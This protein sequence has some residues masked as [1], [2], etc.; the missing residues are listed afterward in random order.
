MSTVDSIVGQVKSLLGTSDGN[1]QAARVL[2]YLESLHLKDDDLRAQRRRIRRRKGVEFFATVGNLQKQHVVLDARIHGRSV[3]TVTLTPYGQRL[4]KPTGKLASF[5]VGW[6]SAE[7]A[8]PK[9]GEFLEIVRPAIEARVTEAMVQ[10]AAFAEMALRSS[11]VKLVELVDHQPVLIMGLPFQFP[12]PVSASGKVL[13]VSGGKGTAALAHADVIARQGR[14]RATKL[15]VVEI[16]K[17]G[18]IAGGALAQ[19]VAYAATV[20]ELLERDRVTMLRALGFGEGRKFL[21]IEACAFVEESTRATVLR[22]A[23]ALQRANHHFALHAYF[24]RM[25]E[26]K[27]VITETTLLGVPQV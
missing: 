20:K 27:P 4:F 10:S 21:R 26:T 25:N 6:G 2:S 23:E 24:Y 16:K 14:G 8:D 19:A 7:W 3:G 9:V 12:L 15:K 5:A 17:P 11:K 18:G 13:Q 1:K 22:D